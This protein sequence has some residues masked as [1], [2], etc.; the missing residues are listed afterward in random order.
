MVFYM[1]TPQ[2]TLTSNTVDT[3]THAIVEVVRA[4]AFKSLTALIVRLELEVSL[5]DI[6]RAL[7]TGV[8][9]LCNALR[10]L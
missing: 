2:F 10:T 1:L 6:V 5:G 4:P 7:S 8:G 9:R 3:W